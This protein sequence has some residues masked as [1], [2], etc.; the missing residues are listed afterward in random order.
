MPKLTTCHGNTDTVTELLCVDETLRAASQTY[1]RQ[2]LATC[3]S[4]PAT[5][6]NPTSWL[7]CVLVCVVLQRCAQCVK[8]KNESSTYVDT[9]LR[10]RSYHP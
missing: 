1:E 7:T 5:I 6:S 10:R 2:R 4:P 9:Q 3:V 8:D